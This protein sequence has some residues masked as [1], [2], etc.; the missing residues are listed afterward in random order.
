M[1]ATNYDFFRLVDPPTCERALDVIPR[2]LR[3]RNVLEEDREDNVFMLREKERMITKL[4][5]YAAPYFCLTKKSLEHNIGLDGTDEEVVGWVEED[6]S[7]RCFSLTPFKTRHKGRFLIAKK[8]IEEGFDNGK[9]IMIEDVG[10]VNKKRQVQLRPSGIVIK[11]GGL[12]NV[13]ADIDV[14]N[15]KQHVL[16]MATYVMDVRAK[17][18]DRDRM[19][20]LRLRAIGNP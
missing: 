5:K 13:Q 9:A 20:I 6:Y 14:L 1:E 19:I 18:V 3:A 10:V 8:S 15:K 16:S 7:F 17:R 12:M 4:M 11:E 2:L